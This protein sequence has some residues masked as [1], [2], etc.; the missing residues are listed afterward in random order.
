MPPQCPWTVFVLVL[1]QLT[2]LLVAAWPDSHQS[3]RPV[4][5]L[6]RLQAF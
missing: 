3:S 5:N 1:A 2:V 6:L 4:S